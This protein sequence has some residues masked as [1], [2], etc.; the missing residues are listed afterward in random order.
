[1]K[2]KFK[3]MSR[4][5]IF[6][7]VLFISYPL[8]N[9]AQTVLSK[10]QKDN[11]IEN[12]KR[13]IKSNYVFI[14]KA[15]GLNRSLDSLNSLG[16]YNDVKDYQIFADEL[17]NDLVSSSSDKH[18]KVQYRP[19]LAKSSRK[20][21]NEERNESEE[22]IDLNFW[23]AQKVNFGF[24]EVEILDGNIGY[25]RLTF[26]DSFQWVKTTIDAAMGFVSNT[27]ALIIDLR[28]NGGGYSSATYL[29]SY[30]F[31]EEPTLWNTS[32]NR[33]TN[34]TE[35]EYTFQQVDGERYLNK[36]IYVLVDEKS[37]S[38]AEGFAY[39]MKHF[40]KATILGQ[41]TPGAAHFI[42]FIEIGDNF[43]I[44]VPVGRNIHPITKTDWEG[45]GVVP[46]IITLKE[47]TFKVAYDQALDALIAGQKNDALGIHY[48]KLIKKYKR[49][50]EKIKTK[51]TCCYHRE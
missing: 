11:V 30:F 43:F 45:I 42:D 8:K 29:A 21:S 50:K 23:Y 41:R 7:F 4:L 40:N 2:L 49:I 28:G 39:G 5:K 31:K 19:D 46:H 51:E 33:A 9:K 48:D 6:I 47:D 34:E 20:E 44:Q 37:F 24:Q 13:V 38:R 14:E 16:R 10:Q 35:N 3:K 12:T 17:T 22:R 18:F 25:I 15:R 1:M 36:P 27:D 26:F 32:F